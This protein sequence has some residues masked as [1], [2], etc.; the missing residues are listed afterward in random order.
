MTNPLS[1]CVYD[2]DEFKTV[3]YVHTDD[4]GIQAKVGDIVTI[5]DVSC[6][7]FQ[8]QA[9]PFGYVVFGSPVDEDNTTL[10]IAYITLLFE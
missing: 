4:F 8:I 5:N 2:K 7:V 6:I 1:P 10:E 9:Q 3:T